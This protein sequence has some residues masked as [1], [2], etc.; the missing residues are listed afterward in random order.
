VTEPTE[1]ELLAAFRSAVAS[2][3]PAHARE[4]LRER[5]LRDA[6]VFAAAQRGAYRAYLE[7]IPHE[8]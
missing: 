1:A 8:L 3:H 4:A 7:R 2:G 6:R 5:W